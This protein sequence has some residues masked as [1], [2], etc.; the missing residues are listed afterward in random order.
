MRTIA[1][2][3]LLGMAPTGNAALAQPDGAYL[4]VVD[5][6]NGLCV[7]ARTPDGRVM[8]F[9]AGDWKYP[10]RVSGQGYCIAALDEIAPHRPLDLVVLSHSDGDHIGELGYILKRGALEIFHPGDA[11]RPNPD[12][13]LI[14]QARN[15]I[16]HS[17]AVVH[18][19]RKLQGD[20]FTLSGPG[21]YAEQ[22]GP[23]NIDAIRVVP[24]GDATV[25]LLAGWGDADWVVGP[26]EEKA[27]QDGQSR[28]R[29]ALEDGEHNN[30]VSLIVRFEYAGHSVLL[31][32]DTVGRHIRDP[33]NACKFAERITVASANPALVDSDVL[34][35]QHHGA[36][37]A[38]SQCF[39]EAVSPRYVVFSAGH[40]DY[41]H[42]RNSVIRRLLEADL[43]PKLGPDNILRT[44][45]GDSEPPKG[46]TWGDQEW[47]YGSFKGCVDPIGDDDVEI[48]LPSD[49]A[50]SVRVNY[51]V[52]K[53]S[54]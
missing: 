32:G 30:A 19:L 48:L 26:Q 39:I 10:G 34:I 31:T 54:C 35:G 21:Q 42:P 43:Q 52:E 7:I 27:G 11:H 49:P 47:V 37:N 40:K 15:A 17:G 4:R 14:K 12:A 50:A 18:D 23:N 46:T 36:D 16:D 53:H 3:M 45:R 51:R 5:V 2:G 20:R 44:D 38:S 13:T 33:R 25:T 1:L 29:A 22:A 9:D 8:L 24:L 28:V 41:R 6:G